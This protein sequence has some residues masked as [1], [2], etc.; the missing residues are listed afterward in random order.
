MP[1]PSLAGLALAVLATVVGAAW[2]LSRTMTAVRV[3][4]T[5]MIRSLGERVARL[6][7]V[8]RERRRRITGPQTACGP[9]VDLEAYDDGTDD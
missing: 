4:L 7:A 8:C 2:H 6:E 3:D 9:V 1:D 5:E